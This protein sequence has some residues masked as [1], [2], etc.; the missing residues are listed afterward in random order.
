MQTTNDTRNSVKEKPKATSTAAKKR[1][2][3]PTAMAA[4]C[5]M[6]GQYDGES[7]GCLP[8]QRR[9][10]A[11]QRCAQPAS[12]P[13]SERGRARRGGSR[14]GGRVRG[15]ARA[16]AA[17]A[18]ID[19]AGR[20]KGRGGCAGRAGLTPSG[21]GRARGEQAIELN[22]LLVSDIS[23]TELNMSLIC[24]RSVTDLATDHRQTRFC[25]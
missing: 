15:G 17:A 25:S 23:A 19:V 18:A 24:S 12:P 22:L 20:A 9:A 11:E 16:A 2:R 1:R 14:Q 13:S 10:L 8:P 4:R 3:D 7:G 6:N 5:P 21:A